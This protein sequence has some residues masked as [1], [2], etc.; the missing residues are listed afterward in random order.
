[1]SIFTRADILL[2]KDADMN[3]W[4]VVACDQYTSCPEYWDRVKN[5]TDNSPSSFNLIFP[6]AYFS[7]LNFAEK[8]AEINL[9]MKKYLD[10]GIFK[11]YK[12]TLIFVKRTFSGGAVRHGIIGAVDL[13]E[14]DFKPESVSS[15][16]ATEKTVEDRLPPRI[17]IRR[18]ASLELPH[19][20]MLIDDK[21]DS[22]MGKLKL[23]PG[24]KIYDFDLMEDGGHIEGYIPPCCDDILNKINCLKSDPLIA[25]GDGNHSLAAAKCC[26]EEIKKSVPEDERASHPMRYALCELVNL[27]ESSLIFEPIYR[28]FFGCDTE[29][30][31]QNTESTEG[32]YQYII[33]YITK[34]K[35]GTLSLKSD[36]HIESGAVTEYLEN[37]QKSY[38]GRLDYIHG[39]DSAE[40]MGSESGNIAFMV[41]CLKKEELFETVNKFGPLPKKTFSMGNAEE[42]RFYVEARKL[43]I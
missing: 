38:G 31:I 5:Y 22:V 26:W 19:I 13:E 37:Y 17:A 8:I 9:N 36:C 35:S 21:E 27:Y 1:M 3:K 2:P 18:N 30:I 42:K 16:R 39:L 15:V 40:N 12:N 10:D 11:E 7:N 24:E 28:V 41:N 20:L 29:R 43:V 33:N 25:V 32:K 14:Y 23:N 4:S 6:E 34:E